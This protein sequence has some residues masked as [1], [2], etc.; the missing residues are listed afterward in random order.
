MFDSAVTH[1]VHVY[2]VSTTTFQAFVLFSP[3]RRRSSCW[4]LCPHSLPRFQMTNHSLP[5]PAGRVWPEKVSRC[6]YDPGAT[7]VFLPGKMAVVSRTSRVDT[8]SN[9][10]PEKRG[11]CVKP[12]SS[13]GFAEPDT[14]PFIR[15]AQS[16]CSKM[17]VTILR[18]RHNPGALDILIDIDTNMPV[19]GQAWY[20]PLTLVVC[21]WSCLQGQ[22]ASR[23]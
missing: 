7:C 9:H 13:I 22:F 15:Q 14:V 23:S 5:L 3:R 8:P 16:S 20:M 19:L 4:S 11:Y 18:C 21:A 1:H 6:N 17:V 10:V 2:Q 12:Q